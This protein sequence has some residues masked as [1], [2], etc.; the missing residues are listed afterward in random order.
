MLRGPVGWVLGLGLL[1]LGG[2][3]LS[4]LLASEETRVRR[5]LRAFAA[6]FNEQRPGA[7]I[8]GLSEDFEDHNHGLDRQ[9]V[10]LVFLRV[11]NDP[12]LRDPQTRA[13]RY[14]AEFVD[15]GAT[16]RCDDPEPGTAQASFALRVH[17]VDAAAG[18]PPEWEARFEAVLRKD[19]GDW[20]VHQSRY[21]TTSGSMPF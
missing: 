5:V 18:S 13:F 4:G 19:Q 3:W 7:M 9:S 6:S 12:S 14:R 1:A 17:R 20:K 15:A 8:V 2:C 11:F 10:K 21:R 16:I